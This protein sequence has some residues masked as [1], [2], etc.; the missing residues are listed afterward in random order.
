[1]ATYYVWSGASGANNG[2]SW[3]NAYVAF[4]SAVAAATASGDVIKVHVGHTENLAAA[5]TYNFANRI[6]A[7]CVDKD[8]ADAISEMDGTTNYI[9]H[10]T[11]AYTITFGGGY[12]VFLHGLAFKIG[13]STNNQM[14]FANTDG[15]NHVFSKCR[16]WLNKGGNT[17]FQFGAAA[18]TVNAY[19]EFD[20]CD[21]KFGATSQNIRPRTAA[22]RI[23]GGQINTTGSSPTTLFAE[24]QNLSDVCII[25]G[26]DISHA[27]GKLVA[28]NTTRSITFSFINCKLASGVTVLATQSPANLGSAEVFLYNCASD[29]THYQFANYNAFGETV[30]STAIYANDGA[31]YDVAANKYSWKI[32]T[33]ASC[34]YYTPY[35]SPW[36]HLHNE[37]LSAITP[38]LEC[39][40]DNSAGAV[41][42][43]D[44][45]W[46]EFS[47][48]GTTGFPLGV[49]VN[50]RMA[51]LGS[52]ANQTAS[53]KTAS[54]WTGETG[55]P[56]FF[57]IGP[58][59][60]ITPAEIGPL[61]ARVCVGKPSVTVYVD[62]QI[63]T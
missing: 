59:S 1:M 42:K 34:S 48:Q 7:I 41:F 21:F 15:A 50:D 57:K 54:D 37:T 25:N 40:R 2:T 5:A 36:V 53:S 16:L 17:F 63:R 44:E 60:S 22:W 58:A 27:T 52:P 19:L 26:C 47:Y 35:V 33:S 3:A 29:D 18:N 23:N 43:D 24:A 46:A 6:A 56:G 28:S 14:N 9:G 51:L 13:G 55:T 38:Y 45:V 49:F 30:V 11:T 39:M 12:N 8:A 32:T 20:G 62:P 4:G 61:S 10:S 31:E